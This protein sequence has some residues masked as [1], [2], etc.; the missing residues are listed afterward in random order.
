MT[1]THRHFIPGHTLSRILFEEIVEPVM[2][3]AFPDVPYA[4]ALIGGGSDVLGFDT[5]R[6]MDHDWG[7]RLNLLLTKG[8]ID[9]LKP[10]ILNEL[11]TTLPEA[12][13]GIPTDLL[14]STDIPGDPVTLHHTAGAGR[15]HGI[16]IE[17]LLAILQTTLGIDEIGRF[18]FA[19]WLTTPEQ[20]LLELTTGPVFRDTPGDLTRARAALAWYPDDL[21][22]YQM[23]ARWKRIAQ[24]EAFIGR[25]GEVG[26]DTGSQ[27][28][29]LSLIE[30]AIKLAFLQERRYAPYAK[31]LGTAFSRLPIAAILQPSLDQA[32]FAR[33]WQEREAG[34]VDAIAMLAIRHNDLALTENVD[35]NVRL[36]HDRPF[37]VIFAER[38]SRALRN[39]IQDPV[40]QSL[41]DDIGSIDQFID[42]TDALGRADLRAAVRAWFRQFTTLGG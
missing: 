22:R 38:F 7:P 11:D 25:C 34:L 6:S 2:A 16:R 40:V 10:R 13:H 27:I 17:T 12:F 9:E 26:D 42:S 18:D 41:P 1:D 14:G 30:D 36:F 29:A 24:M 28:V 20:T 21:W 3:T 15:T 23:A 37:R 35:P 8:D 19:F 33:S 4:A 5:E 32:R 39:S 31:W